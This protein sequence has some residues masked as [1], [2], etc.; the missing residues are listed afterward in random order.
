MVSIRILILLLWRSSSL[1]LTKW[2]ISHFGLH[3]EY[4]PWW[5]VE[6]D[7][8]SWEPQNLMHTNTFWALSPGV[9]R[10]GLTAATMAWVDPPGIVYT[11]FKCP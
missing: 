6:T 10:Q 9:A 3:E 1:S 11:S 8:I 5:N 7:T 2:I 4:A